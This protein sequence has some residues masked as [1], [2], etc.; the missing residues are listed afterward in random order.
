MWTAAKALSA[1]DEYLLRHFHDTILPRFDVEFEIKYTEVVNANQFN[2]FELAP[3]I[4]SLRAVILAARPLQATDMALSN[5]AARGDNT[6]AA[7]DFG[8]VDA[9]FTKFKTNFTASDPAQGLDLVAATHPNYH[10]F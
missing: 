1:L 9:A 8:R 6:N 2:V 3:L 5:E 10:S 7:I 4:R